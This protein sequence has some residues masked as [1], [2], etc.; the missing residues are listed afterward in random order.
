M[1]LEWLKLETSNSLHWLA[2]WSINLGIYN[3][4]L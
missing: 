4:S 2:V 3:W 1:S